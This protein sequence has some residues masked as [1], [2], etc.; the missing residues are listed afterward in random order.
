MHVVTLIVLYTAQ[1]AE[2]AAPKNP[3]LYHEVNNTL[4]RL[5]QEAKDRLEVEKSQ[6][7]KVHTPT[8]IRRTPLEKA[9]EQSQ[10]GSVH[11]ARPGHSKNRDSPLYNE[12]HDNDVTF[13]QAENPNDKDERSG[14]SST[15]DVA[16][17]HTNK[18]TGSVKMKEANIHRGPPSGPVKRQK[19]S[20]RTEQIGSSRTPTIQKIIAANPEIERREVSASSICKILA[21]QKTIRSMQDNIFGIRLEAS[22]DE[23]NVYMTTETYSE[24]RST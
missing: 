20:I 5:V 3:A 15:N 14:S 17:E 2:K 11:P 16:L 18:H 8:P 13:L 22:S 24:R 1:Q 10:Q 9:R 12:D 21:S 23:Y 6:A 19:T 4:L 7:S